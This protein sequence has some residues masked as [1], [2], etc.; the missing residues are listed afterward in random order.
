MNRIVVYQSETGFTRQYAEWIGA[1]LGCE[2]RPIKHISAQELKQYE[3]VIFGG[4]IMGNKK[5]DTV[6][7]Y[8]V[9]CRNFPEK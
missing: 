2:A 1:A 8:C 3:G 4:W 6:Q 7:L 9:C 5:R